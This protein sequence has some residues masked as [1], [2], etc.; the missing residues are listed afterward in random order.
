MGKLSIITKQIK[1]IGK[2][3]V[4]IPLFGFEPDSAKAVFS[5][6]IPPLPN[7]APPDFVD[8][9]IIELDG[10][11]AKWGVNISWR[12][13]NLRDVTCTIVGSSLVG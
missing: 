13:M 12:A 3:Q 2:S 5:G 6:G 10:H 1:V 4:L 9:D 7:C 11:D 8:A